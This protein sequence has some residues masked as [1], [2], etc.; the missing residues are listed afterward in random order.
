MPLLDALVID[1]RKINRKTVRKG[2]AEIDHSKKRMSVHRHNIV[3]N[4]GEAER[5]RG[6]RVGR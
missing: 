1:V 2:L 3:D 5:E 6:R 4:S